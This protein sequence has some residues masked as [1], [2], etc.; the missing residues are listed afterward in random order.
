MYS[1]LSRKEKRKKLAQA[2]KRAIIWS[3]Q[4]QIVAALKKSLSEKPRQLTS[5]DSNKT[6]QDTAPLSNKP[7]YTPL[8]LPE[9]TTDTA[10]A[11]QQ[12][13]LDLHH[14]QEAIDIT[15]DVL[16]RCLQFFLSQKKI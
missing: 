13:L 14:Q 8:S 9:N 7:F 11:I 12:T 10:Q 2:R 4:Q 5:T 15:I 6:K 16:Q 1:H 3:A